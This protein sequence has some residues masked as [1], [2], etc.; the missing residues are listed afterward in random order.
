M[1]LSAATSIPT[2][3]TLLAFD[4]GQK[5]I[6]VAVGNSL[7]GAARP[8]ATLTEQTTDGRFA[9]IQALLKEWQPTGL[10]VGRPLHPDGTPHEVTALAERF[11]RRL[12]GRFGLPVFLVDERYSSVAAQERMRDE[13]DEHVTRGGRRRKGGASQGD[14]ATAAAI[15]LEQYLSETRS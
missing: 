6:G 10:V 9:R 5:R 3:Q 15:I 8:L 1:S 13:D 2:V 7:T 12:E 14:D 11:A 4:F